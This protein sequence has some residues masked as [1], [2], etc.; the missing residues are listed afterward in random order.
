MKRRIAALAVCTLCVATLT[1]QQISVNVNLVTLV[2]TVTYIDDHPVPG[3]RA[4]D[5]IVEEDGKAQKVTFA[6]YRNRDFLAEIPD[7]A[8][9]S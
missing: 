6:D 3:L 2:A 9:G 8:L 7:F 4:E 1:A 5:F